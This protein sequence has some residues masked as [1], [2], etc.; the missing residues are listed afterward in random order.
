MLAS[1]LSQSEFNYQVWFQSNTN[2]PKNKLFRVAG[3]L[4]GWLVMT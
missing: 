2:L 4:A 1:I 3:W